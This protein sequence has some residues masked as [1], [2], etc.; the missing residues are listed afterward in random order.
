MRPSAFVVTLRNNLRGSTDQ[1]SIFIP[2]AGR[3]FRVSRTWVV[4]LMES[5]RANA[6]S[7]ILQISPSAVSISSAR[8]FSSR[9][10]NASRIAS[11][12]LS[13]AQMTKG[14]PNFSR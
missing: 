6:S 14:K 3:P 13:R 1:S 2:A 11:F 12:L 8:E 10:G 9:I 4:R 7:A 5:D